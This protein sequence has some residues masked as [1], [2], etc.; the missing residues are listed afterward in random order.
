MFCEVKFVTFTIKANANN[1]GGVTRL[2]PVHKPVLPPPTRKS[3]TRHLSLWRL[4]DKCHHR[5]QAL[6]DRH[7]QADMVGKRAWI[8]IKLQPLQCMANPLFS[9]F[10]L[11]FI[12][13]CCLS[14]PPKCTSSPHFVTPRHIFLCAFPSVN[15]HRN[16]NWVHLVFESYPSATALL[17]PLTITPLFLY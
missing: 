6:R 11:D 16:P 4:T 15:L 5:V 7:T 2:E 9:T 17:M 13:G 3:Q 14:F 8:F 1:G 12:T 10:I